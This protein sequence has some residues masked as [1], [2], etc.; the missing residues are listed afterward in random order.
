LISANKVRSILCKRIQHK[1][2]PPPHLHDNG[3][4]EKE[5]KKEQ[6]PASAAAVLTSFFLSIIE[7]ASAAAL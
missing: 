2:H 7:A 6:P 1:S 3:R 4:G 5:R